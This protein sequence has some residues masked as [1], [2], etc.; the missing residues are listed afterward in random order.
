[1]LLGENEGAVWG[2][3]GWK[4]HKSYARSTGARIRMALTWECV[5]NK[6]GSGRGKS[7]RGGSVERRFWLGSG[8]GL[9]RE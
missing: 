3:K 6:K 9:G 5:S 8:S 2:A 7:A 1:V 4:S